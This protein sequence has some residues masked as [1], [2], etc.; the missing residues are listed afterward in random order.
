MQAYT[1]YFADTLTDQS[2]DEADLQSALAHL[3][4]VAAA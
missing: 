2:Y 3:P 4:K 1:D